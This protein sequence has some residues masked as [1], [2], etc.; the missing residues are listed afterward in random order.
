M[1]WL[2]PFFETT[3]TRGKFTLVRIQ[4]VYDGGLRCTATHGPSGE[5]LVTD[6]PIDN[7][8]KGESFSP[9]DLLATSMLNCMMTIIA[10]AADSRGLDVSGMSGSVEK[11]MAGGPRRVARL[12][13][14]I[15]M[16]AALSSEDREFL[17]KRGM[18]CP[19]HK[20]VSDHMELDVNFN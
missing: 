13:V 8:G 15:T 12:E 17:I 16:P 3:E 14:E 10:I 2:I 19:V 6:A 7:K 20:S 5:T 4:A 1:K 11:I 9:T 18:A